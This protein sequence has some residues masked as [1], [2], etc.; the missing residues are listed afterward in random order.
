ML[1][2]VNRKGKGREGSAKEGREEKRTQRRKRLLAMV[3]Q[4]FLPFN[5]FQKVLHYN[6]QKSEWMKRKF[7]GELPMRVQSRGTIFHLALDV[8]SG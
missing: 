7:L 2:G 6:L 4:G 1:L 8:H 3:N 5:E